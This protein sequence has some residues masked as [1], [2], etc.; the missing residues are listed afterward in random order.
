MNV[1]D[2]MSVPPV[3]VPPDLSVGRVARTMVEKGVRA[4]AVADTSGRLL[5]IITETDLLVRHARLHFPAYL[6]IMESRIPVGGDRNLDEELR[7][8]LAV[9]AQEVMSSTV[10]TASAEDDAADVA[11][12]MV[13]RHLHAVP[14]LEDGRVQGMLFPG[15]VVRLIANGSQ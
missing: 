9:T 3:V 12:E 8:V 14:I 10:Y 6:S 4:V 2:I 15:D 5:G 1:A 7:R 13:Q 11:H